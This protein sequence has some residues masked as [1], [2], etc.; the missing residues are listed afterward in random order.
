MSSYWIA[1]RKWKLGKLKEAA[2]DST[3]W[4]IGF[5]RGY[6][7]YFYGACSPIAGYGLLILE[8]FRDHTQR[9]TTVGRTP[10]DKWSARR[11]DLY[12]TTHNTHNRQTS[13]LPAGFEPTVSAGE[14]PQT[15]SLDR[16]ATVTG[17]SCR[18]Y[19]NNSERREVFLILT[20]P[21]NILFIYK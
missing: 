18:I 15:Y 5:G 13:M 12:L 10:L 9:H 21:T 8:V 2:L 11:R 1:L 19:A 3:L 16:A 14:R 6:G 17:T 20:R 4:R 7:P